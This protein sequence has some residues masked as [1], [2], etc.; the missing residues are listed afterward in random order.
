MKV[1]YTQDQKREALA[2]AR[3][4]GLPA[5]SRHYGVAKNTIYRWK[6]AMELNGLIE[7][8]TV[9][10][11]TTGELNE[12]AE[13]RAPTAP[14]MPPG[15]TEP[16]NPLN[17]P[18]HNVDSSV[19]S[20]KQPLPENRDMRGSAENHLP[21]ALQLPQPSADNAQ[22]EDYISRNQRL[23][24]NATSNSPEILFMILDENARLHRENQ[25]LRR[26]MQALVGL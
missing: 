8:E 2:L 22:A 9:Q 20:E 4:E 24:A 5:A 23:C 14:T 26:A 16:S 3:R 12:A 21:A 6:A 1:V 10:E 13:D 11:N 17:D 15:E 25:Q 7:E 19:E 18:G